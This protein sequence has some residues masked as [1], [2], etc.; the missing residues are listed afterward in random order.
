M[1]R[2]RGDDKC[3]SSLEGDDSGHE[4]RPKDGPATRVLQREREEEHAD[5]VDGQPDGNLEQL[6]EPGVEHEQRE[7]VRERPERLTADC[8]D[9]E[10]APSFCR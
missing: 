10:L 9:E 2:V 7:P 8:G 6:P 5:E 4:L 1:Q 3:V